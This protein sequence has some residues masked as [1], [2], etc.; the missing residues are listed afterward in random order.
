MWSF[1]QFGHFVPI[2][3]CVSLWL[4]LASS[5]L[6]ILSTLCIVLR[7]DRIFGRYGLFRGWGHVSTVAI[8]N[9]FLF[10]LYM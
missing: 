8:F 2:V 5:H 9:L 4:A 7:D 10:L 1:R 3:V 6:Y